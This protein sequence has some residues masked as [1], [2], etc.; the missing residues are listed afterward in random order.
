MKITGN[1]VDI[2]KAEIY[3]A[4]MIIA[5]GKISQITRDDKEY[6]NFLIP[7][8]VDSHV[9]IESSML[10]PAEFGRIAVT[11]GTVAVVTDPH[12]IANVLGLNGVRFM[13]RNGHH[14][15]LKFYFSAP[16]C[17]PATPFE[18]SGAELGPAEIEELLKLDEVK[19]LGEFMNYPGVIHQ[20]PTVMQKLDVAKKYDKPVD[21][22]APYVSG[23]D[24]EKYVA[25]GIS[26]DHECTTAAEAIEKINLGMKILIRE[27]SACRDFDKLI[28]I[29]E[30]HYEHCMFCCDDLHPDELAK[31]HINLLVKKAL[32]KGLDIMKVLKMASLNPI[33]HYDLEVGLLQPGDSADFL[34]V[35]NLQDLNILETYIKGE[36]VAENGKILLP[37]IT[38]ET[39]N[40]FNCDPLQEEDLKI[41]AQAGK[42][43][44]IE[45]KDGEITTDV[46]S[47]DPTIIDDAV[48]AD[49][50]KDIL[51]IAVINRYQ[52]SKPAVAF[53]RGFGLK[54]GAIAS[55]VAHDSHNIIVIGTSDY[56]MTRAA[57]EIIEKRGGICA[58]DDT[59]TTILAL[60]IAGIISDQD[61]SLVAQKYETLEQKARALGSILKSTFMTLSFMALL[62]I[63][64][65]K[66]SDKG[67]FDGVKFQF[68]DI[69]V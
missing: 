1:L 16:S 23:T 8:F 52:K 54:K 4:T 34:L 44:I 32:A 46:S 22:H 61:H 3:P 45:A 64:K 57:N 26:T 39:P 42:I 62:V 53:I 11:H 25:A 50:D 31:R 67:L 30:T 33:Q 43:K 20:D 37:S 27:G 24:L 60:P 63:P 7:G 56:Y 5:D 14:S 36:K 65:L 19:Y 35:D 55:S 12:E 38:P 21:G 47:E 29:A 10:T 58:V 59:E 2:I 51:K 41:K 49:T 28:S 48:V 15:P 69:W 13:I 66:L 6:S 17:V 40:I 68:T 9:H 18:T